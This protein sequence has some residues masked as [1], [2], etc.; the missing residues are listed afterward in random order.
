MK[1]Y[2][3]SDR[4][5]KHGPFS[6]DELKQKDITNETLIWFEGL[7]DWTPAKDL[8]VIIPILKLKPPPVNTLIDEKLNI[9]NQKKENDRQNTQSGQIKVNH[10]PKPLSFEGRIRRTEYGI[11]III[12]FIIAIFV[13]PILESAPSKLLLGYITQWFLFA[14]GAKRCHDLGNNG[15]WQFIPFYLFW[16]LLKDGKPGF[17]KYG[18][19]PKL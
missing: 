9:E 19:N 11:S 13:H 4:Q 6:L 17:N 16:L 12:F 15:W 3:Y 10:I 1:K 14:Q 5:E 8:D 2:F 18:R 7:K